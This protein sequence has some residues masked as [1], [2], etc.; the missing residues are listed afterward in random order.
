MVA[1]WADHWAQQ[2]AES[3]VAQTDSKLVGYWA[4]WMAVTKAVL[5]VV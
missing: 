4:P 1:H 5:R 2:T 3:T